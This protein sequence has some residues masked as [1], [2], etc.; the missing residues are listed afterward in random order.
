MPP[1]NPVQGPHCVMANSLLETLPAQ[2]QPLSIKRSK[3]GQ[4]I[5][6]Y[7]TQPASW[8]IRSIRRHICVSILPPVHRGGKLAITYF[9]IQ[10]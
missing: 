10:I 1:S 5:K 6:N 9:G 2:L 8:L 3:E 7:F 4:T